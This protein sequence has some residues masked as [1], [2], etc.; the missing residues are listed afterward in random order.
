MHTRKHGWLVSDLSH[1][2]G[3]KIYQVT[4]LSKPSNCP[5]TDLGVYRLQT[6]GLVIEGNKLESITF[7]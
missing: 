3:N 5:L 6:N 7:S 2:L 4:I 1:Y